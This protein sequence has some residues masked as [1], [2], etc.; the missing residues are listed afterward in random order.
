MAVSFSF[1]NRQFDLAYG[2]L[3]WLSLE[4]HNATSSN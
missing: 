4:E 2:W 3:F 1:E